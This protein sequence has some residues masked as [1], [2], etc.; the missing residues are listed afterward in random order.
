M[1]RAKA[2]YKITYPNGNVYI[3]MDLTG[4]ADILRKPQQCLDSRR[5]HR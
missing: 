3:G 1:D 2:I 4:H 5:P